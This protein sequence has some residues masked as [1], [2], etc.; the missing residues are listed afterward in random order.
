MERSEPN[1]R[2]LLAQILVHL[3]FSASDLTHHMSSW[4]N[5]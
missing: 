4:R 3:L 2:S 1:A 5:D